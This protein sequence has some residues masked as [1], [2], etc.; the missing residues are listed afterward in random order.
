MS[1]GHVCISSV[2][3]G[4]HHAQGTVHSSCCL[5]WCTGAVWCPFACAASSA[6]SRRH[7]TSSLSVLA[8][9]LLLLLLLQ[10]H[11]VLPAQAGK[12]AT[13]P[14]FQEL[15]RLMLEAAKVP[16]LWFLT[17]CGFLVSV[18]TGVGS[19]MARE[20]NQGLSENRIRGRA[21][22]EALSLVWQVYQD[23]LQ[24]SGSSA[25]GVVLTQYQCAQCYK[26]HVCPPEPVVLC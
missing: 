1:R 11:G 10:V 5:G 12:P 6:H 15:L 13:A 26:A 2:G 16:I 17:L 18:T 21:L 14:S 4:V 24:G 9:S 19:I 25:S 8:G 7:S 3:Q 20:A 23:N 22:G